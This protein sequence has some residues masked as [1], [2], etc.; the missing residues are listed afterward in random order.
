MVL[1]VVN[2]FYGG[3][4]IDACN[5][6]TGLGILGFNNRGFMTSVGPAWCEYW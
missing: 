4:C 5:H 3:R 6:Y 1:I 2:V